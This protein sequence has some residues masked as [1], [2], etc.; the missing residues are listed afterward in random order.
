MY[1]AS[2]PSQYKGG[3]YYNSKPGLM[4]RWRLALLFLLLLQIRLLVS[5]YSSML[6]MPK[7]RLDAWYR[8]RELSSVEIVCAAGTYS[9]EFKFFG[10][11]HLHN[12]ILNYNTNTCLCSRHFIWWVKGKNIPTRVLYWTPK[13]E[14]HVAVSFEDKRVTSKITKNI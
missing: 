5:C 13:Y 4:Q 2:S 3:S 8:L 14:T 10:Y 6:H 1:L 9:F 7:P 12:S 11:T